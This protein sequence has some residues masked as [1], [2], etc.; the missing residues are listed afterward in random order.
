MFYQLPQY[1]SSVL[2]TL[3]TLRAGRASDP[4]NSQFYIIYIL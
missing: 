3:F 1:D 2:Q 4:D